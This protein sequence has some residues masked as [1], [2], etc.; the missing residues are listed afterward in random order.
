[1]LSSHVLSSASRTTGES[2]LKSASS[3]AASASF[4]RSII[5]HCCSARPGNC[6]T[7]ARRPSK[8]SWLSSLPVPVRMR[9]PCAAHRSCAIASLS[10]LGTRAG[11]RCGDPSP[12]RYEA[13]KGGACCTA[14]VRFGLVCWCKSKRQAPVRDL[15]AKELERGR[16]WGGPLELAVAA[17]RCT[18]RVAVLVMAGSVLRCVF[19]AGA[20]H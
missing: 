2:A 3:H 17:E 1:M 19:T 13:A 16:I 8:P 18:R 4:N 7:L 15:Y 12:P 20:P 14:S 9:A 11:W 6:C 10:G 5:N